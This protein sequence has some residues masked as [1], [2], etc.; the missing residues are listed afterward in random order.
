MHRLVVALVTLLGL[1]GAAVVAAY[2]L[3]FSAGTDRA[4]R[5]APAD[6]ALYVNVY[7][8]PSAGQQMNLSQ[9]IGRFPGFADD[10]TLDDKVDQVVQNLLAGSGVDYRRD[11]K[12]W[13]GNQVA[14]AVWPS[15]GTDIADAQPVVLAEVK[16]R[17]AA[18][19]SIESLVPDGS[20]FRTET[21]DGVALHVSS[22]TT[23][24]FV[25][26][27]L[28]LGPDPA[29]VRRVIDVSRGADALADRDDFQRT[30]RDMPS[31]HLASAF[32]DLAA[33]AEEADVAEQ[34]SAVST[35]GAVLVAEEAGL[36]LSGSAPF[37]VERADPSARAAFVMSREPSSLTEWMPPTTIAEVVIFGL[38]QTLEDA[39]AAARATPDGQELTS[40]LDTFRAIAAFGLGIDLDADVLPLF[41]R[42]VAI[43]LTG[44]RG[45]LPSGQL[46]LRPDDPGAAG[47]GLARIT[48]RL[49]AVGA[50]TREHEMPG[51]TATVIGVPE[52]GE[53][54]YV[55]TDAGI[56][57]FAFGTED[58][59]AAVDAH[60]RGTSLAST[61]AYRRTFDT[62]GIR[63][64][65]E[66]WIDVRA[67]VALMQADAELDADTRD[68]LGQI[69]TLG[70]TAPSREDHI[71]F[72]AVLT[73]EETRPD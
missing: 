56:I 14:L 64:G 25:E 37:D 3:L 59:A 27:M 40:A 30:M 20:A 63:A 42:E 61:E 18:E 67:L 4:A 39:E 69:G 22:E 55:V 41:D 11:V 1:T 72:H 23:Y 66:A 6:T 51:G 48:E 13:L 60:D 2:L 54:A 58:L 5:L 71:E 35:A 44:F 57:I 38:R 7:L 24:A 53:V 28:V 21:H 70:F 50:T 26:E 62:A 73:V 29:G 9:L 43:A 31:D 45:D 47:A 16:D 33:V 15:A 68:I 19:A 65:N 10:A 32:V 17:E 12:P 46:L 36:R 52:M 49:T 8:Q 34:L